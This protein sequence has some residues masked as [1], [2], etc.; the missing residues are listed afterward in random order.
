MRL[1]DG[2]VVCVSV[3]NVGEGGFAHLVCLSFRIASRYFCRE[4]TMDVG[5]AYYLFLRS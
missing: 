1:G 4:T 3:R 5:T 2:A